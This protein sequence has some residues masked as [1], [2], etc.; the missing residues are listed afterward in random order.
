LLWLQGLKTF[1]GLGAGL[2]IL[3]VI[4]IEASLSAPGRRPSTTNAFPTCDLKITD[5]TTKL[6]LLNFPAKMSKLLCSQIVIFPSRLATIATKH[7]RRRPPP[8]NW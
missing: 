6:D 4:D 1:L 5:I 7:S 8:P 2:A 3:I